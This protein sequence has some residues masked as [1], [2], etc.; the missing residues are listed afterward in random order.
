MRL[1]SRDLLGPVERRRALRVGAGVVAIVAF[2]DGALLR[3]PSRAALW[4]AWVALLLAAGE[5][6]VRVPAAAL[7]GVGAIASI[8][9]IAALAVLVGLTG[10]SESPLFSVLPI[11]PALG[12]VIAPDDVD[13]APVL[14]SVIPLAGIGLLVAEGRPAV[15][16]VL[17]VV[18]VAL[19]GVLVVRFGR[20]HRARRAA[21]IVAAQ[22][23]ADVLDRLA[24]S[25][26]ELAR[27]ERLARLPLLA[28]GVAHDLNSPLAVVSSAL[29]FV[30]TELRSPSPEVAE[31][32]ADAGEA[33]AAMRR[34]VGGLQRLAGLEQEHEGVPRGRAP[35]LALRDAVRSVAAQLGEGTRVRAE[36]PDGLPTARAP[37]H[38]VVDLLVQLIRALAGP[39]GGAAGIVVRAEAAGGRLVLSAARAEGQDAGAAAPGEAQLAVCRAYVEALGGTFRATREDG[40]LRLAAELPATAAGRHG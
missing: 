6:M 1:P 30:R 5:A 37:G 32:L 19:A 24:R 15:W 29:S 33:A 2:L 28:D 8:L 22:E 35:E 9:S 10:G 3:S 18:P 26:R 40:A 36:I 11:I 38:A 13:S 31:A 4:G 14:A 12:L 34:I 27:V 39:G 20:E 16:I 21:E 25:E 7:R 17:W 23:R